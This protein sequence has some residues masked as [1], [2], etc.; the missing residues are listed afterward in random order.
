MKTKNLVIAAAFLAIAVAPGMAKA[1][2]ATASAAATVVAPISISKTSD[3]EFGTV[4]STGTA[5]TVTVST[6]G[7][8]TS[9]NVDLLAGATPAAAAFTVSGQ[10]NAT[11]SVSMPTTTTLTGGTSGEQINA[12]LSNDAT[13]S[14]SLSG[15]G[16]GT[17]HVGGVLAIG[18]NQT[19]DSYTGSF[20]VTVAYN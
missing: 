20:Q 14:P 13:G 9:S 17:L 8:R 7:T 19:P 6:T 4:A 1:D 18:A 5:G 10:A 11:Y 12:T 16:A 3:L 15:A 2:A